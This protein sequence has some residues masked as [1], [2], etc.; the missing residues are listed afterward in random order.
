MEQ[1][2]S[3][4]VELTE[5]QLDTVAGGNPFNVNNVFGT[6]S[7]SFAGASFATGAI[8]GD[9]SNFAFS[10]NAGQVNTFGVNLA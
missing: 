2:L 5:L 7:N 3:E 6:N 4:P 9:F 1:N 10:S 8:S